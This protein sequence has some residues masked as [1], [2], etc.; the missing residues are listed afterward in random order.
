MTQPIAIEILES[1]SEAVL[2][3]DTEWRYTY[4]NAAAELISGHRREDMLGRTRHELFPEITGTPF[5]TACRRAMDERVTVRFEEYYAPSG[6]WLAETV[7]PL[8]GGIIVHLQD[9]TDRKRTEEALR[10]SEERFRRCFEL[11]LIGM[12]LTSGTMEILEVNDEICRILGYERSELL[13]TTWFALTHQDDRAED[14]RVFNQVLAGEFDGYSIDKR[15]IRKDGRV[16]YATVAMKCLRNPDGTVDSFV[17]FLQDL[18]EPK[19]AE[20]ESDKA[21]EALRRSEERL[22]LALGSLGMAAWSWEIAPDVLTADDYCAVLFG[23]APGL[24]PRTVE[25]FAALIHP[26]EREHFRQAVASSVEQGAEYNTEFR[27]VLPDRSR[28]IPWPPA[29][30]SIAAKTEYHPGSSASSGT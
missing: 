16:V 7:C 8:P 25:G 27:V 2:A 28:P 15:F 6:K 18:T 11:G 30:K 24:F 26:A 12:S 23:L 3:I 17:K 13:R 9:I 29:E 1:I 19:L 20:R 10:K 5:D 21:G 4:V 22:R 14:H